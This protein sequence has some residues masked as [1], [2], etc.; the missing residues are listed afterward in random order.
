MLPDPQTF[1]LWTAGGERGDSQLWLSWAACSLHLPSGYCSDRTPLVAVGDALR[2]AGLTLARTG[3][4]SLFVTAMRQALVSWKGRQSLKNLPLVG[5]P[6][7][8]EPTRRPSDKDV[9]SPLASL[10]QPEVISIRMSGGSSS[11]CSLLR[12]SC[13]IQ[14]CCAE[15]DLTALSAISTRLRTGIHLETVGPMGLPEQGGA[16]L[17]SAGQTHGKRFHRGIQRKVQARVSE[18]ELVPVPR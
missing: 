4:W 5:D 3:R 6:E 18:R 8:L 11:A 1:A 15:N 10:C 13:P 7:S 9:M 14:G 16:G 2:S 12:M 17:L